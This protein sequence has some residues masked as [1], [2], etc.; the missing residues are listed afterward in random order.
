NVG[1]GK[2]EMEGYAQALEKTGIDA[3]Q[4]R[5]NLIR[6]AQANLV[7][8]DSTDLARI[9]QNAAVIGQINS[10]EA[11]QRMIW[12]LQTGNVLIL[13]NIGLNVDFEKSYR[14]LGKQLNR[15]KGELTDHEKGIAKINALK[16]AGVAIEKVYLDA[17]TTASKQISSMQRYVVNLK[18]EFGKAFQPA[19]IVIVKAATEALKELSNTVKDPQFQENLKGMAAAFATSVKWLA[20]LTKYS[21]LKLSTITGGAAADLIKLGALKPADF[22]GKGLIEQQKIIDQAKA[23]IGAINDEVFQ[24]MVNLKTLEGRRNEEISSWFPSAEGIKEYDAQINAIRIGV[25]VAKEQHQEQLEINAAEEEYLQMLEKQKDAEAKVKKAARD[26]LDAKQKEEE[27]A[28]VAAA[29]VKKEVEEGWRKWQIEKAEAYDKDIEEGHNALIEYE[30]KTAEERLEIT[31]DFN[32]QYSE[33]GKSKFDLEREELAKNVQLW[34]DAGIEKEKILKLT[35]DETAAIDKAE[36]EKKIQDIYE[37]KRSMIEGFKMISEMG[38]KHS[39]E[40]F[41][42][43]KAFKITE[44]IISTYSGAMKAYESMVGIPFV[45]PYLAVAAAAA[46]VAF[47]MAQV[48]MIK[49][50]QPPSYDEGGIS[51]KPGIY[52]SGVPEAHIPLK[53]GTVPVNITGSKQSQTFIIHMDNPVFQDLATQ[54]QVFAQIATNIARK[55]APAA[56][57]ENYDND[58]D[59]RR[60]IRSRK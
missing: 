11:F 7:L 10:S 4:S 31:R 27:A 17:M 38:G 9:A 50:S 55:V 43:Y 34:R 29:K 23:K 24:M 58:G 19:L 40:A 2:S 15:N 21:S 20:E 47:G 42:L 37:V 30:K 14:N 1:V 16:L 35:A 56:V 26:A 25:R 46:T 32:E 36:R 33:M 60:I 13:R 22:E 39:K 54:Q 45:G 51:T 52:Y 59:I 48:A 53:G 49:S 28:A 44:T 8:K 3:I 41:A 57:V 18:V 6:M 12:G 5:Q